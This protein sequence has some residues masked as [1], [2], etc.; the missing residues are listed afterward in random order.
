VE[1]FIKQQFL[2][3]IKVTVYLPPKAFIPLPRLASSTVAFAAAT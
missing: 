1:A 2:L 3:Q